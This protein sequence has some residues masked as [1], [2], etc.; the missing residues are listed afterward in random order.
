MSNEGDYLSSSQSTSG[1]KLAHVIMSGQ[2]KVLIKTHRLM[3]I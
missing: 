3:E 1:N 2:N